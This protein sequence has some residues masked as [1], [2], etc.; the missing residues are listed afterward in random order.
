MKPIVRLHALGQSIW[1]DN[2]ERRLL[3]DGSL[4][5]LIAQG[6]IRGV[7]SNPSIFNKAISSS[8]DYDASLQPMAWAGWQPERIFFRLAVE[9]IR[10][11]ADLFLP[12]Y[13]A[14][15]GGDGYVSLEVSPFLA[16]KSVETLAQAEALWQR[17]K[18]PNLMIKIPATK[19]GIPAVREC[20]AAGLNIN[21]TLIFSLERYQA[22]MGAYLAG[23]EAR[24]KKGLAI[25]HI[26]SVA[27]FFVSR[28]DTKIDPRLNELAKK[29]ET[30]SRAED[31]LGKA[32]I[33]NAR[34]AYSL[35]KQQFDAPRFLVL[36]VEGARVQRPL[37]ASTSTKNPA[38]R[39]VIYVE[40]L[41]GPDTVNTI[42]PQT[43]DAFREHGVAALTLEQ[44]LLDA[45]ASLLSLERLGISMD[46]V[47][48]E[49]ENEGVD[50]FAKAFAD[51]L[52]VIEKRSAAFR[53]ELGGIAPVVAK[54]IENLDKNKV[55]TRIWQH[56]PTVWV[57]DAAG[58]KVIKERMGWLDT[59]RQSLELVRDLEKFRDAC[60]KDGFTHVLLLGMGGSS[61][62]PEVMRDIFAGAVDVKTALKFS[63]LD[64]TD[65]GQVQAA[66]KWAPAG[67]TLYIVASKSGGTA[68]VDAMFRYFWAR[69]EKVS[70]RQAGRSFIAITDPGTGLEQL[71]Q[72]RRFRKIFLAEP[73]V[74][75]RS[76]ALTLFGLVPAV[77]MGIDGR[78]LLASAME[79]AEACQPGVPAGANPGLVLGALMGEAALLGR[80]KLTLITDGLFDPFGPWL[81]QLVAESSGKNGRGI[82][83][84]VQEPPLDADCYGRDRLFIYL[85]SDGQ[86]AGRVS[87]IVKAGQPVATL[88]VQAPHDL[89]GEFYRWEYATAVA[90]AILGVNAFD[91]PDVQDN[92][93]RTKAKIKEYQQT[94]YLPD[95]KPLWEDGSFALYGSLPPGATVGKSLEEVLKLFGA[96]INTGDYI[97][98][99]AY[100]TRN[101]TNHA[102]LQD[103]RTILMK[104][105]GNA[106]TL[107][108]G[109]RFLHSTG[110]LHKGG[111]N[112]GVFFMI[113]AS[114]A[115]DLL[116]PG[117]DFTF[118]TLEHA[119][120][121]GDLEALLARK[122]RVLRIHLKAGGLK[123]LAVYLGKIFK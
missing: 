115:A 61:L 83:P 92:K 96:L 123:K 32:A 66:E 11:T 64:S 84:V 81:E 45:R 118:G 7:T 99:N 73:T 108:F 109:P 114:P 69:V 49:L 103:L 8:P 68:E 51:L 112:R 117:Q 122:R 91:Q 77:L 107:G 93:D 5:K 74:G 50:A 62:A 31:L 120:A 119:Q 39:D 121:L 16:D 40:E 71:G 27:S 42:P 65:P 22:V 97:A 46:Q 37:W 36:K 80:N 9:D 19:E 3:N 98:L 29:P 60:L 6:E 87:A 86:A 85:R 44:G 13:Q 20:I 21:V 88:D 110:Q 15:R 4:A 76:S 47:T 33:A 75:G 24:V 54:Q 72:E 89:G 34:V 12:L 41:I 101:E 70:G 10:S 1:Y 58:G 30:K 79:M 14:S 26:A 94:Q 53:S 25:D 18:R 78:K 106:T 113:T 43:L 17:V 111:D 63:I 82:L 59:P 35:F 52:G 104:Y 23:L 48:A 2:I 67:R 56:D 28:V 95:G 90:C 116:I 38:Y 100:L 55:N 57:K 105:H 102:A